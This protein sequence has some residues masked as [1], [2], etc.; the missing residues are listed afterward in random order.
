[1]ADA[2]LVVPVAQNQ[3]HT[4]YRD[5]INA[6]EF[7]FEL[8][9]YQALKIAAL[10]HADPDVRETGANVL[11]WDEPLAAF[12]SLLEL[13]EDSVPAVAETACNTLKYYPTQHVYDRMKGVAAEHA[14]PKVRAQAEDSLYEIRWGLLRAIDDDVRRPYL[15][16]WLAPLWDELEVTPEEMMP[17]ERGEPSQ[18]KPTLHASASEVE[19]FLDNLDTSPQAISH[20]YYEQD[21]LAIAETER[22]HLVDRFVTHPD[23]TTRESVTIALEQWQHVDGLVTLFHDPNFLVRKSATY[24][25]SQLQTSLREVAAML[26][27]HLGEPDAWGTHSYETLMP[28]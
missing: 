24:H 11:L 4:N 14:D 1:M 5:A 12:E 15:R 18:R 20:F 23:H 9:E 16:R 26:W 7:G 3:D 22:S 19:A 2:D 17:P 27:D 8:P 6:L 10:S 25:L 28:T 21:W 13:T